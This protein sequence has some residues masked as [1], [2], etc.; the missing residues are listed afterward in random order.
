MN[1]LKPFWFNIFFIIEC[2]YLIC[3]YSFPQGRIVEV[4]NRNL[5]AKANASKTH[6]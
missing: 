6:Q 3:Y 4:P 1:P 5:N 2:L